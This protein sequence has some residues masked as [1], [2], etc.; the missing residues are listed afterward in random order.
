[1]NAIDRNPEKM[2]HYASEAKAAIGEMT[3]IIRKIEGVLDAYA[4]KLD[5]PTQKQIKRLHECCNA[6]FKQIDT[7]QKIADDIYN[8]GKRLSAIRN[9]G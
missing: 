1:M 8:K 4:S 2:M 7:Y 5:D 3:L 6:F 9:G